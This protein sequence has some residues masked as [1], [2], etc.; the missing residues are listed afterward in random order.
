MRFRFT[1]SVFSR[2]PFA[3]CFGLVLTAGAVLAVAQPRDTLSGVNAACASGPILVNGFPDTLGAAESA[4]DDSGFV[5]IFNGKNLKGWWEGCGSS[6]SSADKTY[7][8]IW[9]VDSA[10]GLLFANQNGNGAGS[11]LMTNKSYDNYELVFDLWPSFGNDAG[12]FNRVTASGSCYQTGIDYISG[13]SV[14]GVYFEGGYTGGSRNFDPYV[15]SANRT[16][17]IGTNSNADNRLDTITKRFS[18]PVEYGC[19]ATGCG[20]SNWTTIWDTAGWNQMRVQFFGTG[21]SASSK[22][23]N[24]AWIRKLG[25][26]KWVPTI[27]DSVQYNT[28]A[29]PI[30]LQIHG[31]VAQWGNR[32]GNWYRNIRLRPL[33]D[34]GTP[35]LP[36]TAI[37]SRPG[38]AMAG[39]SFAGSLHLENGRISGSLPEDFE[40]RIRDVS[41]RELERFEG[42][43][44]D[45]QYAL[46][47]QA[48]GIL[49]VS[50]RSREGK[51]LVSTQNVSG[52]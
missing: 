23:H 45:F 1:F 36:V 21:A 5:K 11:I 34:D 47:T 15:F 27:R 12:V 4:P 28:P 30:G 22:V 33:R 9:L 24:F 19:P 13:S 32:K 29:N 17:S 2:I 18:N 40:I 48:Q 26:T 39:V 8:G 10:N 42:R 49:I 41:G 44:G 16:I 51:F 7:G 14:G 35:I 46:R 38:N 43:A 25:S 37:Q 50:A 31:T 3:A 52:L 20:P 6:H